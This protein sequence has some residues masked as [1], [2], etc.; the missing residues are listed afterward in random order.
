MVN[1]EV[2]RH[3]PREM[4]SMILAQVPSPIVVVREDLTVLYT[5][6][7]AQETLHIDAGDELINQNGLLVDADWEQ[8]TLLSSDEEL[9]QDVCRFSRDGTAYL[10]F[11]KHLDMQE[12]SPGLFVLSIQDED[13]PY[14]LYF[15]CKDPRKSADNFPVFEDSSETGATDFLAASEQ[16]AP[17]VRSCARCAGSDMTVLFLGESGSGKTMLAEYVHKHSPRRNGPF[18]VLN[19]AAIAKDLLESELFGYAPYAFTNANAKGKVGLFELADKGTLLLDEIG[20]MPLDL[21]AK[22][23]NAVETQS[24]L[25]IG[26]QEYKSVDVRILAATNHDLKDLVR[27]GEFREDLLWR[28]NTLEIKIPPLR[29]RRDD[30]LFIAD[31]F[32]NSYNEQNGTDLRFTPELEQFLQ[33]YDWPGNVC[34]LKNTVEKMLFMA[35]ETEIPLSSARNLFSSQENAQSASYAERIEARE[36]RFIQNQYQK[37]PSTRKLAASLDISQSTATR[38]IQK[39]V[40]QG[41]ENGAKTAIAMHT[42]TENDNGRLTQEQLFQILDCV[43][44]RICVVDRDLICLADKKRALEPCGYPSRA[45]SGS[46]T[47]VMYRAGYKMA[48]VKKRPITLSYTTAAGKHR[49]TI[50]APVM[51]EQGCDELYTS[52]SQIHFSVRAL[53]H[54]KELRKCKQ[55][56]RVGNK[57]CVFFCSSPEMRLFLQ[58]A[59]R[60][61]WQDLSVLIH[62]ESGTGKS[63]FAR[64]L[65]EVGSRKTGPFVSINCASIPHDLI[66]SELFGYEKG[67]FTGACPNGKIGLFEQANGG[68]LFLDE[69]GDMPLSAQAKFLDVIENKRF[70]PIGGKQVIHSDVRVI[71]ATNRNLRQLM[72]E[73]RFRE[74]LYWRIN[75]IELD[76]PALRSRPED[77]EYYTEYFLKLC[78]QKYG[79]KKSISPEVVSLFMLYSWPGNLRQLSNTVERCFIMSE[80]SMICVEDLP[81]EFHRDTNGS[82]FMSLNDLQHRWDQEIFSEAIQRYGSAHNAAFALKVSDATISRKRAI[83]S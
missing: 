56:L 37:Y 61:A 9:S 74:D 6:R 18:I 58:D 4:L 24:I 79:I 39:Y 42:R 12:D 67:A 60:A 13:T 32:R 81:E 40:K 46:P 75:V 44:N 49:K 33:N 71:C 25:P 35:H 63:V 66:E 38:L 82:A 36:R 51:N 23:L 29:E 5:N 78:N 22:I 53:E 52:I 19:C 59:D 72:A 16:M 3:M 50:I 68:T 17:V 31:H 62:G 30:I 20:D 45:S 57:N 47:T 41:A 11:Q 55:H 76:V 28:L 27:R 34:Q 77:V 73:K 54:Q 26:A 80:K 70:I 2:F 69:I 83:I 21:Q 10:C 14:D 48:Q 7:T 1:R 8:P 64:Y 15:D 43:P 65:H